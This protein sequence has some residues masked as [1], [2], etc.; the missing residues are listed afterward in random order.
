M[1]LFKK[2]KPKKQE[3]PVDMVKSLSQ[4]GLSE[5]EIVAVLRKYGYSPYQIERALSTALKD[6]VAEFNPP[7]KIVPGKMIKERVEPKRLPAPP[8][9]LEPLDKPREEFYTV[10][11]P[12]QIEQPVVQKPVENPAPQTVPKPTPAPQPVPQQIYQ[13][14]QMPNVPSSPV[15]EAQTDEEEKTPEFTFEENPLE[16]F[17][18]PPE[19]GPREEMPE[20][21]LEEIIE[22]I[23]AEKW[24]GFEETVD[25]L[26]KAD[27]ELRKEIEELRKEIDNIKESMKKSEETLTEKLEEHGEHVESIE[28]RIGSI[29]KIFKEF[30]PELT[31]NIRLLKEA[32]EKK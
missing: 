18:K 24:A 26:R 9:P 1:F 23:V 14:Q 19:P 2:P 20:I 30:I 15:E 21:T 10:E 11:Q 6:T 28:A 8:E 31:E 5:H 25:E 16:E 4:K 22:S 17:E 12:Q 3:I 27:S 32:V 7:E 29:E 13:P